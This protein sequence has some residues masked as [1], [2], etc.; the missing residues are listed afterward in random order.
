MSTNYIVFACPYC[1]KAKEE[2][3]KA[4]EEKLNATRQNLAQEIQEMIEFTAQETG[5]IESAEIELFGEIGKKQ[6]YLEGNGG[7][8]ETCE[9]VLN[10]H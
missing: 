6:V 8:I 10:V 9:E 3:K 2:E 7:K 5:S 4:K 1:Q